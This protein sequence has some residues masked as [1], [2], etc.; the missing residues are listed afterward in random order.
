MGFGDRIRILEQ[1]L[2]LLCMAPAVVKGFG[3]QGGYGGD[4]WG[5]DRVLGAV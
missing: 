1:F 2:E 3:Q 5:Q 4:V